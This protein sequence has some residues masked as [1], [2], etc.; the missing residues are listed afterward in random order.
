MS[1][2]KQEASAF[3]NATPYNAAAITINDIHREIQRICKLLAKSHSLSPKLAKRLRKRKLRFV[4]LSV[5][6]FNRT[7]QHGPTARRTAN[8]VNRQEWIIKKEQEL[9]RR[10]AFRASRPIFEY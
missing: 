7:R 2:T 9:Q 4:A 5:A 3:V 8:R 10:L 6:Y 1:Y